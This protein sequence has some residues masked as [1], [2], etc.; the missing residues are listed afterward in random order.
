MSHWT[1]TATVALGVFLGWFFFRKDIPSFEP[2]T[3]NVFSLAGRNDL[4]GDAVN[5][6]V[7]VRPTTK[8][9]GFLEQVDRGVVDGAV[10]GSAT[11]LAGMSTIVRKLQNGFVRSYALTMIVGAILVGLAL[12]LGQLA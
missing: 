9:A 3:G 11:G 8:L 12:I 10:T 5:D 4:Y 2:A 6:A 1:A 7:V